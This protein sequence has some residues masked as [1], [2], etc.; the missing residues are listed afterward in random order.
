MET[1]TSASSPNTVTLSR[2]VVYIIAGL[3]SSVLIGGI[4]FFSYR[5]SLPTPAPEQQTANQTPHVHSDKKAALAPKLDSLKAA[6][7][8]LSD[9]KTMLAYAATL[10]DAE[11]YEQSSTMYERFF[12]LYDSTSADARVEYAFTLLQRGMMDS[13][14]AQTELALQYNPAHPIALFNMGVLSLR[15]GDTD[16]ARSWLEKSAE[17]APNSAISE[18]VELVLQQL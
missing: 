8:K 16:A 15:K 5:A 6:L 2:S 4:S 17:A 13:A 12:L 10:A 11:E 14:F 18:Q 1:N 3:V 7:D 9:P